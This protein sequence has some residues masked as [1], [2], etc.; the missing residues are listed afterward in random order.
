MFACKR[1]AGP[2]QLQGRGGR[3][4][5]N[6][7]FRSLRGKGILA[8]A[9]MIVG[10]VSL[11][12]T[13]R[14]QTAPVEAFYSPPS[15][16]PPAGSGVVIRTRPLSSAAALRHARR[17]ILV[18]YH[19]RTSDGRDVA[20]S[21]TIAVPPGR[22]PAGGWPVIL[23]THGTTGMAPICAPSRDAP[24]GPEH[25]YLTITEAL[26]DDYVSRGYAVVATDYAGLGRPGV[27]TYLLG[28][29]EGRSAIDLLRAARRLSLGV[30]RRYIVMGHSQGGQSALFTTAIGPIY[31][32]E[33][34]LAGGVAIAPASHIPQHIAETSVSQTPTPVL[35][36]S[37]YALEAFAAHRHGP[38]LDQ[39]LSPDALAHLGDLQRGC[40]DQAASAGYWSSAIPT[41]QFARPFNEILLPG[42]SEATEPG[43]LR[44]AAPVFIAQ[45]LAD[46][47][48]QPA[49]TI[50][51]AARLCGSRTAVLLRTYP[52]ADHV[53]A[54]GASK[55]DV[56]AWVADRFA[57]RTTNS[58]CGGPT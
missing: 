35:V 6:G 57:G 28:V 17:N 41:R 51:V 4:G 14:A 29:D 13:S 38:D 23:W 24:D 19:S 21:G 26:L 10:L 15:P 45:G 12:T 8:S 43:A 53:G 47:F 32:P 1:D 56:A 52:D 37:V 36:F 48:I 16:L 9:V 34:S 40:F 39:V 55:D 31:A 54:L 18:L 11:A 7:P 42:L 2:A 5:R 27:Q 58:N 25:A 46:G 3:S 20:V 22:A 50:D 33:L 30:G 49:T 44:I